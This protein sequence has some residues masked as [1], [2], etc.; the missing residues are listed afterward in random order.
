MLLTIARKSIANLVLIASIAV[1]PPLLQSQ[2]ALPPASVST[3]VPT[4][5]VISIKPN[6][7]DFHGITL[8]YTPDGVHATNIPILFLIK[9]AFALND[10]QMFGIPDWVHSEKFD[11]D[12]KVGG[13]DVPAIRTLTHDQR[14]AMLLEIL[15]DRFKLAYHRETRILPEYSLVIAKGGSKLQE[16]RPGNDASGAPKHAGQMKMQNG[17]IT[18]SGIPIEPLTRFLSDRVGRPVIDKTGLTGNYDFTRQW[19]DDHH[20]GP[21]PGP[22]AAPPAS[23]E[24]GPSIFTAVEEQLGLKL[25]SEKGP[26][27]VVLIDHIVQ[28]TQN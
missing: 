22:D 18:A 26:V 19:T 13:S 1:A 14:R 2:A 28:P 23:A 27:Q 6:H 5:D 7:S 24:S 8:N 20:D 15:S 16:F 21:P 9:E 17:V 25:Q 10:D 4:F 11:I 12:A 3:T